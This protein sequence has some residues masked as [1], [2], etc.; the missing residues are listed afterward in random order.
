MTA[1][2]QPRARRAMRRPRSAV[3]CMH[4][5]QSGALR[6]SN[7]ELVALLVCDRCGVETRELPEVSAIAREQKRPPSERRKPGATDPR[8]CSQRDGTRALVRCTRRVEPAARSCP[9]TGTSSPRVT[10]TLPAAHAEKSR[11][12]TRSCICRLLT[13]GPAFDRAS[14]L[15]YSGSRRAERGRRAASLTGAASLGGLSPDD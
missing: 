5:L 1:P 8:P 9:P 6:C 15:R 12:F 13:S 3:M 7:G 14:G 2:S 4:D 11:N 10:R